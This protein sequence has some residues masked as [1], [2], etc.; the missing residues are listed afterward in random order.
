MKWRKLASQTHDG[1]LNHQSKA[2]NGKLIIKI[3]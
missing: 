1:E 2:P 3:K